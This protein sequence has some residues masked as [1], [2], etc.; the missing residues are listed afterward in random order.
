[1]HAASLLPAALV[2]SVFSFA[3]TS[4]TPQDPAGA[5]TDFVIEA[6]K[7]NVREL[8]DRA[9][10]YLGRNYIYSEQDLANV[11]DQEVTLQN[12]LALDAVGCREVVS[13]LAFTKGMV[14]L[15]TDP[16]RGI[17]EWI[18]MYGPNRMKLSSHIIEMTPGGGLAPPPRAHPRAHDLPA[19]AA[20][21]QHG[22]QPAAACPDDER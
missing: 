18:F 3:A 17:Y 8:I 14:M 7:H 11:P 2:A 20:R 9:A 22:R 15:P 4:P 21:R 10:K 19:A 12:R 1:M 13:E 6:G 5:T 16:K